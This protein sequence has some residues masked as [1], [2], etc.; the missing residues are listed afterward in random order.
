MIY[1][2]VIRD[3]DAKHRSL[4]R[5]RLDVNLQL[6][7][8]A[9]EWKLT[10]HRAHSLPWETMVLLE[11][12]RKSFCVLVKF[13]GFFLQSAKTKVCHLTEDIPQLFETRCLECCHL[14]CSLQ[15]FLK[16]KRSMCYIAPSPVTQTMTYNAKPASKGSDAT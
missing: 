16:K 14:L 4:E 5:E 6:F 15:D 8:M 12:W 11:M 7:V 9:S 1:P 13:L 3:S 10:A 2:F